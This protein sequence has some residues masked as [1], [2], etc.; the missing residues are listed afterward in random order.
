MISDSNSKLNSNTHR[1]T[2][3]KEIQLN[4]KKKRFST[5]SVFSLKGWKLFLL[6]LGICVSSL[7]MVGLIV[8]RVFHSGSRWL[9]P[10]EI[11]P[12]QIYYKSQV[13]Y[14]AAC[15]LAGI[16]LPLVGA[17]MQV[18]TRNKLAEPT[19]LGFYPIIYM[20]LLLSQLSLSS[21]G[22]DFGFSFLLSFMVVFIN[23]IVL[24]GKASKQTFKSILIGFAL[25]AI[26]TGCNY[27]I[28]TYSRAKGD[29]LSWL[30]GSFG[31]VTLERIYISTGLILFFTVVLLFLI[32]YFNIIQKDYIIAKTLGIKVDL[33]Y[34]IV[35]FSAVV[36][37]VSSVLIIGGVVLIGI[38]VPHLVRI[39]FRTDDNRIVLP[40]SALFGMFLLSMSSWMVSGISSEYGVSLNINLLIALISVPIFF[41]ILRGSRKGKS[42]N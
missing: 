35:A 16:G 4:E 31:N 20:G 28:I 8:M 29:P 41:L 2:T 42:V 32:P 27:L 30:T 5:T 12:H 18:T 25:N 15:I 9:A 33:I 26:I 17:S 10:E 19:T 11:A 38:V 23:F 34:W 39:S 1:L 21:N 22:T 24:R 36:I 3:I 6:I 13:L 7:I 37:T 40:F 14:E